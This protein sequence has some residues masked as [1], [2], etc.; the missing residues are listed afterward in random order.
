MWAR[1]FLIVQC[2]AVASG[3]SSPPLVKLPPTLDALLNM[4]TEELYRHIQESPLVAK[5]AQMEVLDVPADE[6]LG[7]SGVLPTVTAHGMGDSCFEP[8]FHSVTKLIAKHTGSYARCVSTGSNIITD[9]INGFLMN[10]D[11]S[12][13]V[14]A[15]KIRSDK[16][17]KGGFNAIGFS[18][19]N[20]LIRGYIQKY[21][22]PPVNA[23]ISVHGTVMGVASLPSCFKQGKPVGMVCKA[24]DEVM[25]DLAYNS[26]VQGILF[27]A[28]YFR[29]AKATSGKSYKK[30]SQIAQWN[31]ENT[32][33]ATYTAN[34][35]KTKVYAMVKAMQDTMVYPNEGEHWG[36]LPDGTYGSA[37]PMKDTKFYKENLFGLKD[38]DEAGKI[39][40]ETTPGNHLQFSNEQLLSWLDKYFMK[41]ALGSVVV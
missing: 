3:S 19:G 21:N 22:D 31:N 15:K 17:L 9:T 26:I 40:Y 2:L 11:K 34:F 27:Q 7:E 35:G 29:D 14:F 28:D 13:D 38:A 30:H 24:L 20:S 23:F 37:L 41:K 16:K 4:S 6:L 32:P 5:V 25:G 8:G 10:M 12:V 33:D 39:F 1:G 36:S 18:Q